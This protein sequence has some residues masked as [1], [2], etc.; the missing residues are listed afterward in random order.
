MEEILMTRKAK[1]KHVYKFYLQQRR[2][3]EDVYSLKQRC[4]ICGYERDPEFK[5]H[6]S[7]RA[8]GTLMWLYRLEDFKAVY[9][10]L[11]VVLCNNPIKQ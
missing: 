6:L 1:H 5:A 3:G 2:F 4:T 10:E 11:P 8:D 7:K 9:G